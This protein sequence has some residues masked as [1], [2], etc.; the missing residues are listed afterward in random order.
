MITL[1]TLASG[2]SGNALLVSCGDTHI[3]IDAGIS[4]RRIT[5]S[6][7]E[8]SLSLQDL[9]ALFITHTHADHVSGLATLLKRTAFPVYATAA[10]GRC[11]PVE[12]GRLRQIAPGETVETGECAVTAF[13]TSHD[14]PGAC[15][16]RLDAPGESLGV[17]TDTGFVPAEAEA[18]LLGADLVVLEANHDVETLRSGPYPD[19]LKAR[20]L[21]RRGHLSNDDA[22][23]LA[24]TLAERGTREIV[25][26]HLSRE[27]NTPAMAEGAVK[28]ALSAEGLSAGVS[29]APRDSLSRTY[30]VRRNVCRGSSS[31][32]WE[33]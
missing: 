21:G 14:A 17:I 2:S 3:L 29:V 6:L 16:Y 33:S 31:S 20:I 13:S 22:A 12:D 18:A 19:Y 27:N 32:V 5:A 26:A 30:T 11:L 9:N 10:A 8:L 15:G 4:C 24:V 25:L 7:R 28:R 23:R 1:H